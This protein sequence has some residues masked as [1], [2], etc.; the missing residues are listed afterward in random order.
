MH[1]VSAQGVDERMIN[2]HYYWERCKPRDNIILTNSIDSEAPEV[3]VHPDQGVESWKLSDKC[4][5]L[6]CDD[7]DSECLHYN[8]HVRRG[9]K[10][11]VCI[12][13][14]LDGLWHCFSWHVFGADGV[15]FILS[16]FKTRFPNADADLL[17]HEG[18]IC[19]IKEK[20]FLMRKTFSLVAIHDFG[21]VCLKVM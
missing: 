13:S 1:H 20:Y 4:T 14:K 8:V 10:V 5:P 2:V 16:Y 9:R 6:T 21:N 17:L 7:F 3:A 18:V 15:S 19:A 11:V 12:E